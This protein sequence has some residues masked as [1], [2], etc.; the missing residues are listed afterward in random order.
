VVRIGLGEDEKCIWRFDAEAY[1]KTKKKRYLR[2]MEETGS[3][4]CPLAGFRIGGVETCD[5][6]WYIVCMTVHR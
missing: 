3:D 2:D 6:V 1:L 4:S 5:F